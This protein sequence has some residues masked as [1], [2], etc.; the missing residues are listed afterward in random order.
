MPLGRPDLACCGHGFWHSLAVTAAAY[1]IGPRV[2]VPSRRASPHRRE[3]V[4]L[5]SRA[6]DILIALVEYAGDTPTSDALPARVSPATG[7]D[8]GRLRVHLTALRKAL[9]EIH[10][11]GR[12]SAHRRRLQDARDVLES[13]CRRL[14]N[15]LTA[16]KLRRGRQSLQQSAQVA[17]LLRRDGLRQEITAETER[18]AD[19]HRG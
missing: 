14:N 17:A 7:V 5:G 18:Q 11:D 3:P 19:D 2:V 16:P 6:V 12:L 1:L 10:D 8:G 15:C 13:F 4:R 9:G